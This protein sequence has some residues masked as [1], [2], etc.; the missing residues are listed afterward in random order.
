MERNDADLTA[1]SIKT[2]GNLAKQ[3]SQ[4]EESCSVLLTETS[5]EILFSIPSLIVSTETRDVITVDE[6]NARYEVVV[7]KS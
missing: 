7:K 1:K 4:I 2:F 6:R 3:K 5:T